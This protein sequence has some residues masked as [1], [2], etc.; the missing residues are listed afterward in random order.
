MGRY[1]DQR[2]LDPED[3][4]I[5]DQLVEEKFFEKSFGKGLR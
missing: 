3:N 2:F 5:I 4:S 1:E